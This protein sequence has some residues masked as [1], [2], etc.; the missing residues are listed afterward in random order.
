KEEKVEDEQ[1][2]E[3]LEKVTM[4]KMSVKV[5]KDVDNNEELSKISEDFPLHPKFFEDR[6][7]DFHT[8]GGYSPDHLEFWEKPR[9]FIF[10]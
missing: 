5:E 3:V 2:M 6:F 4:E 8:L 10:A 9:K 1:G 7:K